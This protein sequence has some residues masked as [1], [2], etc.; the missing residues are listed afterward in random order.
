MRSSK[1]RMLSVLL[2]VR[3]QGRPPTGDERAIPDNGA[4]A[5]AG[6]TRGG[7]WTVLYVAVGLEMMLHEGGWRCFVCDQCLSR[8]PASRWVVRL[9]ELSCCSCPVLLR[10]TRRK[11]ARQVVVRWQRRVASLGPIA[12]SLG[13][14][15]LCYGSRLPSTLMHS[16]VQTPRTTG[17]L[18]LHF[19]R[20][21]ALQGTLHLWGKKQTEQDTQAV[22]LGKGRESNPGTGGG[23]GP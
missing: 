23:P 21:Q 22:R 11:D 7:I 17:A 5:A 9:G 4:L 19:Y 12:S 8:D 13:R 2:K 20:W 18:D 1:M 15:P 16:R 6:M 3:Q 14:A 10:S